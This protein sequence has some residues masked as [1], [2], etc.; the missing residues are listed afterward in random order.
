MVLAAVGERGGVRRVTRP[1]AGAARVAG[2]CAQVTPRLA[3]NP[4]KP[5]SNVNVSSRR[6]HGWTQR[7]ITVPLLVSLLLLLERLYQRSIG[8]CSVVSSS[9]SSSV[10]FFAKT[11]SVCNYIFILHLMFIF[12]II[13][14]IKRIY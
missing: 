8:H 10:F 6:Q 13:F 2:V 5:C 3:F 7:I 12:N 9:S 4:L 1:A 11:V 14:I